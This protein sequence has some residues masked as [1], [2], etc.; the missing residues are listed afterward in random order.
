ML[1]KRTVGAALAALALTACAEQGPTTSELKIDGAHSIGVDGVISNGVIRTRSTSN[2]SIERQIRSQLQYMTGQLNGINGGAD[3]NRLQLTINEKIPAGDGS[4]EVHYAAKVLIAWRRDL[5]L[6]ESYELVV[7][8]YGDYQNL[9]TFFSA[10]QDDCIT[11]DAHDMG[12]GNFWYYYRPQTENCKVRMNEA[13]NV[14]QVA[15]FP[16]NLAVSVENTSGQS[17]ASMKTAPPATVMQALPPIMK[18][19]PCF[20]AASASPPCRMSKF[21][22]EQGPVSSILPLT[23]SLKDPRVLWMS[24]FF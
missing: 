4:F 8:A 9:E 6:P 19:M 21:P 15:R 23:W 13:A 10:F 17:P 16:V 11:P 24:K 12:P 7:P 3:L 2:A 20:A 18:C 1:T 5:A 14:D 22:P